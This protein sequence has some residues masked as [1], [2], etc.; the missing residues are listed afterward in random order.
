[1]KIL[2]RFGQ[3]GLKVTFDNPLSFMVAPGDKPG[4]IRVMS[5]ELCKI[6]VDK[7]EKITFQTQHIL[8]CEPASDFLKEIY[9]KKFSKIVTPSKSLVLPN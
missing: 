1:M 3:S 6:Q 4:E 8:L 2:S 9:N 7:S 5:E